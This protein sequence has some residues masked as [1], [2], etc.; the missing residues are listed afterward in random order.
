VTP[1]NVADKEQISLRNITEDNILQ[2]RRQRKSKPHT[3][4]EVS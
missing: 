1:H 4:D 2:N 3:A